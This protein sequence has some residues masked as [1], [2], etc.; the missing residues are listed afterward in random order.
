LGKRY[1]EEEKRLI[2]ELVTQGHTDQSI[3]QQLGRSTNAIR[4]MR[5]RNHQNKGD[6]N[7]PTTPTNKTQ[8][9][10]TYT[11]TKTK[12]STTRKKTNTATKSTPDR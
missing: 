2:Q 1:T 5:H 6:T 11:G 3:P 4:N 7:H 12:T 9:N 10:P 8:A